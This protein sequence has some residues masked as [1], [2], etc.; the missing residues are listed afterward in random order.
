MK[1]RIL[2][3]LTTGRPIFEDT[4]DMLAGNLYGF[5]H[6]DQN[7]IGVLINYDP[8]LLN[9][10]PEKF[11]YDGKHAS[12]FR[13]ILY[14]GPKDVKFYQ[15]QM[16]A[17]GLAENE[18][19]MLCQVSGFGNKKNL[20]LLC[21]LLK[22][23]DF[24]LFWDDDEYP[25]V[26]LQGASEILWSRTD[27]LGA[28]LSELLTGADVT[29]GFWTGHVFPTVPGIYKIL[30]AHTAARLG[31][32]LSLGTET[33]SKQSFTLPERSF[34]VGD[35]IPK[36]EEM[37]I[38]RGGKW[39]SGGN[40]AVRA[41]SVLSGAVPPYYTPSESRGDDTIFSFHLSDAK[42]MAVPGGAFHDMY[43]DYPSITKGKYPLNPGFIPSHTEKYEARFASALKAWLAYA[44]LF[45]RLSE[46]TT[47]YRETLKEMLLMLT[48]V[49]GTLFEEFPALGALLRGRKLAGI[50]N[51][52]ACGVEEQYRELQFC[53]DVWR[54]LCRKI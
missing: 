52:Y 12:R 5:G 11:L 13:E 44:P 32:A 19:E 31:E 26:C 43:L 8:L 15:T 18:I 30:S 23:Y 28:H 46:G 50:L 4:L 27:V 29:C 9:I 2:I 54:Q 7:H 3:A 25:V 41:Q 1:N 17:L 38:V 37:R 16:K 53:H 35:G 22:D 45:I 21:A 47:R 6:F 34:K 49:D 42:V 51:G 40:L 10:Q 14:L 33:H 24:V 39:V 36:A 20:I 48:E